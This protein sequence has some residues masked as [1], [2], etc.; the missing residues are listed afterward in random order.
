MG[1]GVP[2]L[3]L[4]GSW[5][6]GRTVVA[7][8]LASGWSV[9]TFRRG[10]TGVDVPGV[11]TIR[12]DRTSPSGLARLASAGPWDLVV[13]T[14]GY[15]PRQ[16]GGRPPGQGALRPG[17][18]NRGG[19]PR[20]VP[21]G[22]ADPS[23]GTAGRTAHRR[24]PAPGCRRAHRARGRHRVRAHRRGG[25]PHGAA[26]ATRPAPATDT[27][28]ARRCAHRAGDD[29]RR[30]PVA[31]GRRPGRRHRDRAAGERHPPRLAAGRRPG[32][33]VALRRSTPPNPAESADVRCRGRFGLELARFE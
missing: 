6:L 17:H 5:F 19:G 4:G 3:V 15:V 23:R 9:C 33:P 12:G 29:H 20:P 25:G 32:H 8:A 31:P 16:Q 27:H 26:R 24:L 21:V 2:L 22:R 18:R 28:R 1:F 30:A 11:Q 10:R 13:D 14:S 7:E